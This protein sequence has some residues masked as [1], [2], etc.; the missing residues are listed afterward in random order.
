MRPLTVR[1]QFAPAS[2][3]DR[4]ALAIPRSALLLSFARRWARR[5][6]IGALSAILPTAGAGR[7]I[8]TTRKS[9]AVIVRMTVPCPAAVVPIVGA[10][11]AR[12]VPGRI[13]VEPTAPLKGLPARVGARTMPDDSPTR[14][15]DVLSATNPSKRGS[16]RPSRHR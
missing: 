1:T 16:M 15:Q 7:P 13:G 3:R 9:D 2:G 5:E 12:R 8:L 11:A 4:L 14:D 6:G 10:M